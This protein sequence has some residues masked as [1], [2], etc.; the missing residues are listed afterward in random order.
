MKVKFKAIVFSFID[1]VVPSIIIVGL[2][3]LAYVFY[4]KVYNALMLD[5]INVFSVIGTILMLPVGLFAIICFL[6]ISYAFFSIGIN[7]AII[8]FSFGSKGGFSI[9]K[10]GGRFTFD[11]GNFAIMQLLLGM[12]LF[13]ILVPFQA[14]LWLIR[15]IRILFSKDY[16]N[17]IIETSGSGLA[18]IAMP[19]LFGLI[20]CI[21]GL[22]VFGLKGIQF[23]IYNPYEPQPYITE[24]SFYA[25]L[26][27]TSSLSFEFNV[28]SFGKAKQI[29]GNLIIKNSI[30]GDEIKFNNLHISNGELYLPG[31]IIQFD[32]STDYFKNAYKTG[33]D[34][35]NYYFEVK[36]VM[37][38][39]GSININNDYLIKLDSQ[40][41]C[42]SS[43]GYYNYL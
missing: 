27:Y 21:F 43:G 32:T 17:L 1:G 12:L 16:A 24:I 8:T 37:F 20:A 19:S 11:K 34:K 26:Q 36:N 40:E 31:F 23:A 39:I 29:D 10:T 7:Q 38:N 9:Y 14:M 13:F 41:Y 30:S 15:V 25:Q 33:F 28:D 6:S 5:T 3:A 35:L 2:F 4:F 18:A 22:L 42:Y